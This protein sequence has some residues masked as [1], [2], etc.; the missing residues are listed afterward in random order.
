MKISTHIRLVLV[1]AAV[2]AGS[3]YAA[4]L[5]ERS[6][7]LDV[8]LGG[9]QYNGY[10]DSPTSEYV[11]EDYY[12]AGPTFGITY[13]PPGPHSIGFWASVY[14]IF[15]TEWG[16]S[17]LY[18]S[19]S[20]IWGLGPTVALGQTS[21]LWGL[22]G[23]FRR[24]GVRGYLGRDFIEYEDNVEGVKFIVRTGVSIWYSL[25]LRK[26]SSLLNT[27]AEKP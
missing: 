20:G 19:P 7:F 26:L 8:G 2:L 14:W 25:R 24:V 22:Q 18:D 9:V 1:V 3:S 10:R 21:F 6:I 27:G 15:D 5:Y 4:E 11:F 17:F 23:H 13:S 16:V 12:S